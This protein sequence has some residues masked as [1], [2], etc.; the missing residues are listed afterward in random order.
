MM[1]DG[2]GE[3]P[4]QD[5]SG[6]RGRGLLAAVGI[7]AALSL[8]LAASAPASFTQQTTLTASDENGRSGI[9]SAVALSANGNIALVGGPADNGG[10]GAVWVFVRSGSMWGEQAKLTGA[11]EIGSGEFGTSVTVS[12]DG[13]VALI[14]GT[15]DNGGIGAAWVFVRRGASWVQQ[16]KLTGSD[17]GGVQ[18]EAHCDVDENEKENGIFLHTYC[19]VG[20]PGAFG[21]SVALSSNGHTALVGSPGDN[22]NDGAAWVFTRTGAR[23][24]QQG[25]KL[26]GAGETNFDERYSPEHIGGEFGAS[27]AL[28]ADGSTALVGGPQNDTEIGIP[29]LRSAGAAWVFTRSGST[30]V[31]QGEKLTGGHGSF[32]GLQFGE[33]VA[34]SG[35]ATTALIGAP[36]DAIKTE[37]G[38]GPVGGALVFTHSGSTWIQGPDLQNGEGTPAERDEAQFGSRLAISADGSIALIRSKPYDARAR[39]WVFTRSGSTWN[40]LAEELACGPRGGLT[41][42]P[43]SVALSGDGSTALVGTAVYVEP[44]RTRPSRSGR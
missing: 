35:D 1:H 31:Q 21:A 23:W 15:N 12:S 36:E 9:G 42:E 39:A 28:S 4:M 20:H 7:A 40:Q 13:K 44:G 26:I 34:L 24:V 33:S 18:E 25:E 8:A 27:V 11:G 37:P 3:F 38:E 22:E 5:R 43:C 29:G 41:E 14:G 30:W 32:F 2:E 6:I 16:E 19:F 10:V 17:A